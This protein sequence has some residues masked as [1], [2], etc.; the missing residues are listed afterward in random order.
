MITKCR[1]LWYL[2]YQVS[3]VS[4]LLLALLSLS[5]PIPIFLSCAL[6]FCTGGTRQ[7]N[8]EQTNIADVQLDLY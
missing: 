4:F 1:C 8:Q 2:W 5:P 3:L 7:T 6:I